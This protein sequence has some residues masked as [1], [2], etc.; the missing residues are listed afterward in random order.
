MVPVLDEHAPQV[1]GGGRRDNDRQHKSRI[2]GQ[3]VDLWQE[4]DGTLVHVIDV[5]DGTASAQIQEGHIQHTSPELRE[6]FLDSRGR[7]FC[8]LI[9]HVALTRRPRNPDQPP[10]QLRDGVL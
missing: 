6:T 8:P 10:L 5:P 4:A 2:A 3:L 1:V 7:R 9:T